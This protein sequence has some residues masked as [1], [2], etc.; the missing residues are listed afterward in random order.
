MQKYSQEYYEKMLGI[1]QK[2]KAEQRKNAALA[3][4]KNPIIKLDS[5][6][7]VVLAMGIHEV[8][9]SKDDKTPFKCCRLKYLIP[10]WK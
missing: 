8:I 3:G 4:R 7:E 1:T 5:H 9:P 10:A 2:K 6:Y